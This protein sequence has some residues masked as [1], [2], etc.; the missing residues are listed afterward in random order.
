MT[1]YRNYTLIVPRA[2]RTGPTNVAVDIGLAAAAS[3]W[4]VSLLYLS[5]HPTRNDLGAFSSVRKFRLVD[6]FRLDGIIHSHGLRPDLVAWLFTWNRRCVV[7]STL[8][9]HFPGHLAF[10]YSPCKVKIAWWLWSKALA[11][12]DH[13]ICISQTMVR[14]YRRQFRRISL[15]L[16]YNFRA[17]DRVDESAPS[18]EV[19]SWVSRQRS[20]GRILLLY[21]GSLSSRKNV[22]ALVEAVLAS[23]AVSLL[24]CGEGAER[25]HISKLLEVRSPEDR[26]L[27]AGHV[28]NLKAFLRLSDLLV[29]ASRAEGLPLVV[30]EAASEGVPSLLSNLAVHRELAGLGFG[31]TFDR[32]SF[33]DF[34]SKAQA[35]ARERTTECDA[36]RVQLW[37][38]RFSPRQGFAQYEQLF[39]QSA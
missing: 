15:D 13:R 8:H 27:L 20:A 3:G 26:V 4:N 21:A 22:R 28:S 34:Q 39:T 24:M 10:D 33:H 17:D 11:R 2:D 9:G 1:Q 6:A 35:L 29:L 37:T 7:A 25:A 12:F 30:L 16:A 31:D 32:Y 36:R 19:M 14:F 18:A 23:P 5:G 38:S